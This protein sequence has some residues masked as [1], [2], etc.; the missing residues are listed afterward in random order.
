MDDYGIFGVTKSVT[1][2]RAYLFKPEKT[3][4]GVIEKLLQHG[5]AVEE[6]TT[7]LQ[8]EVDVFTIGNVTRAQRPFQ[9]HR[10]MKITGAYK[11]ESITFPEGTIIVRTAQPLGILVYYLLEPESED[12]LMTWNFF[13]SYLEPGKIFP[14]YKL[15]Q[16]ENIASRL[17]NR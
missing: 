9:N 13:D 1:A 14:V 3:L 17:I 12:G 11:K 10:E 16:N 5:I 4:Q 2:P 7:P 8:A 15:M 6:L